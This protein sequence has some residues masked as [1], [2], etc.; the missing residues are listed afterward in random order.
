MYFNYSSMLFILV[1]TLLL[2]SNYIYKNNYDNNI[3]NA[4]MSYIIINIILI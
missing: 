3:T 4:R 2:S 1:G